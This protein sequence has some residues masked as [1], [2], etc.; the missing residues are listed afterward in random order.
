MSFGFARG[1][2]APF[3]AAAFIAGA[4]I[5]APAAAADPVPA[6]PVRLFGSSENVNR[7]ISPFPKWT[8]MLA[9]YASERHLEDAPCNGG[10]CHLQE[11]KAFVESLRGEDPM[12]Q[13]EAV[14][15]YANRIAYRS[16][17]DRHGIADYWAT[18]LE[19][20][21][22]S[23]DCEDYAII[24]Y[25][26]LRKLGW[27]ADDLR[28]VVLKHEVRNE[29]H[30]VLVAYAGGTAWVLDNL[31]PDVRE[32][33]AIRHYRPIFSI[34]EA[35]WHYHRDW[36]PGSVA[37]VASSAPRHPAGVARALPAAEP[38]EAPPRQ[39]EA[40]PLPPAIDTAGA[41]PLPAPRRAW[42]PAPVRAAPLPAARSYAG[43]AGESLAALFADAGRS[44]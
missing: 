16:D 27:P 3:A 38:A 44:R 26:S 32:H 36:S 6:A 35:A 17:L 24:K 23:A 39:V 14:N 41:V 10:A 5:A 30:A 34:N 31:L 19:S 29:L 18:P 2:W 15:A 9:R 25:L 33:A 8:G 20:F 7:D 28:I 43:N 40:A 22:R 11:W 1:T 4:A 12:M 37:P 42:A 13:L 21:G